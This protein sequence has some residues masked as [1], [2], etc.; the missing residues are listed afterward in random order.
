MDRLPFNSCKVILTPAI[1]RDMDQLRRIFVC[2][3]LKLRSASDHAKKYFEIEKDKTIEFVD[4]FEDE[5][6]FGVVGKQFVQDDQATAEKT[7]GRRFFNASALLTF[8]W[9]FQILLSLKDIA[10]GSDKNF[11][12]KIE[13]IGHSGFVIL[14]MLRLFLFMYYNHEKIVGLTREL[15]DGFPH[16]VGDQQK[17]NIAKNL[18]TVKIFN[19]LMLV[20][21]Y[22]LVLVCYMETVARL[23]KYRMDST[24]TKPS[25]FT[26]SYYPFDAFQ[27]LVYEALIIYEGYIL[28]FAASVLIFTELFTSGLMEVVKMQVDILGS[29]ISKIKEQKE[30]ETLIET[31]QNLLD[32]CDRIE[33]VYAPSTLFDIFGTLVIMCTFAFMTFAAVSKNQI[34]SIFRSKK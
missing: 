32:I 1:A 34:S 25:M 15:K 6:F 8:Q 2:I 28:L 30:F 5:A 16:L 24:S 18:K 29:K 19:R 9:F 27:P 23:I 26:Y 21:Y 31:H 33:S 17:H 7:T 4:F 13:M 10:T 11:F 22:G 3:L 14:M 20:I 12:Q